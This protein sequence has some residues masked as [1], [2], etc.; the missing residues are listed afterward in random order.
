LH[1]GACRGAGARDY[2]QR[3]PRPARPRPDAPAL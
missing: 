2:R 3:L 1:H